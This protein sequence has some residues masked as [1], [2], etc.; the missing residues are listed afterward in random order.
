MRRIRI[1]LHDGEELEPGIDGGN[2]VDFSRRFAI[3]ADDRVGAVHAVF[4]HDVAGEASIVSPGL[5]QELELALNEAI[6]QSLKS[7]ITTVIDVPISMEEDVVPMIP[8]G[9]GLNQQV[10]DY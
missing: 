9:C 8:P 10:G 7:K 4:A 3:F 6:K 5:L 2:P 1:E